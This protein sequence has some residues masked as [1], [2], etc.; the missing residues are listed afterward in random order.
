MVYYN[1]DDEY[2]SDYYEDEDNIE[3]VSIIDEDFSEKVLTDIFLSASLTPD[4]RPKYSGSM[5]KLV[6][7]HGEDSEVYSP[8]EIQFIE[9]VK[10]VFVYPEFTKTLDQGNMV[11]RVIT[12]KFNCSEHDALRACVSFEKIIDKALDGFN[13]F[14]FVTEESVF[15]G[16]RIF[17][18]TGKRDCALSNPITDEYEFEQIIDEL[19]FLEEIDSFIEYYSNFQMLISEGQNNNEDYEYM[20]MSRRGIQPSY[21]DNICGIEHDMR[22]NMSGEKE[23]YWN[24]FDEI[25]EESFALLLDEVEE[26]LSFIKSNRVNSYEMLFE[27]DEMMRRAEKTEVENNRLTSEDTQQEVEK[28]NAESDEEAQKLL[29][30]P[31][32][33]IKLLKKR[34]GI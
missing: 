7:M 4:D 23:R 31:E 10:E 28:T 21:L 11:C 2:Y 9:S 3:P 27:A 30:D 6:F 13:I 5:E 19:S 17:D 34:K 24:T 8:D 29:N 16:C 1:N 26:D 20:I 22:L 32:E 18:K 14:F 12:T 15:F 25:H 33:I